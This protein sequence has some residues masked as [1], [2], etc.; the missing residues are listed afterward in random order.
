MIQERIAKLKKRVA[1]TTLSKE[2]DEALE[3]VKETR[4]ELEGVIAERGR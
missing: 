3:R 4:K 1:D 2:A